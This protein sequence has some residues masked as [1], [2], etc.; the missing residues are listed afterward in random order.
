MFVRTLT[1]GPFQENAYLLADQTS[2]DAVY[3]DPGDEP[4]RLIE[5]VEEG[6]FSLRAIWITHAHV[7][8]VGGITSVKHRFDVPVYLHPLDQPLY[9]R[10]VAQGQ[11]F[12]IR[13]EPLP[14][15]D[16]PL[17]EGDVMQVGALSFG[18]MHVP[19]HAP[20]HV[21]FAGHGV[22][23]GGDCL[24]AGSVGR[25]DLPL[26][27]PAALQRSLARLGALPDE[28]V[29]YPGHGPATTIGAE[30]RSNPFLNGAVRLIAR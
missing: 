14:A 24:L 2:R 11:R 27:D 6:G 7:D 9:D 30:N 28:T 5:A 19:G 3:I 16:H 21:A 4:A 13:V 29:V 22:V 15:P 8:H 23:F 10:A 12:G 25:T 17:A 18:V 26:C 1:V 20:G